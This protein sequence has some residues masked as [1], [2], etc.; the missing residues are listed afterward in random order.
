MNT[1]SSIKPSPPAPLPR[2]EGSKKDSV[3][4]RG[5]FCYSGLVEIARELRQNETKAEKIV[6][7]LLRNR[8]FLG[9]KFRRQHQIGLYIADFYC[10]E[11]KLIL[12]LDGSIHLKK[13]QKEK[14]KL[15]DEYFKS[16]GFI[17]FRFKNNIVLYRP[18]VLFQKIEKKLLS[19]SPSSKLL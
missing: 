16:E 8:G 4:Y 17:V 9:L 19:P 1:K 12:E 3:H 13:E 14:D 10:D 7:H 18:E 15:R 11:L 6:W 2:G 5:G